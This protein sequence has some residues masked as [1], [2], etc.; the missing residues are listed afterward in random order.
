MANE[1]RDLEKRVHENYLAV[2][3]NV[4]AQVTLIIIQS[5]ISTKLPH[6]IDALSQGSEKNP[7]ELQEEFQ[8]YS[9]LIKFENSKMVISDKAKKIV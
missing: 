8:K 2:R 9:E 5:S 6:F 1:F 4:L 3:R 7:Y